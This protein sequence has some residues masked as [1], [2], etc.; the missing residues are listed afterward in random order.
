VIFIN[1]RRDLLFLF[2]LRGLFAG[3]EH[4]EF[5]FLPAL[6]FSGAAF[7]YPARP[8]FIGRPGWVRPSAWIWLF[9]STDSTTA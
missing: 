9:S 3:A 4:S 5:Y 8:F 6:H 1:S 7:S 2:R